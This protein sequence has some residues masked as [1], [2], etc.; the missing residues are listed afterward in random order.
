MDMENPEL[1]EFMLDLHFQRLELFDFMK[2]EI[3][4]KYIN[5]NKEEQL[6]RPNWVQAFIFTHA[7]RMDIFRKG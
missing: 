7:S 3:E 1:V 5:E 6:E 4:N 2:M